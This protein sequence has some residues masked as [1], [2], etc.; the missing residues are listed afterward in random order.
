MNENTKSDIDKAAAEK[1]E[2]LNLTGTKPLPDR[3]KLPKLFAAEDLPMLGLHFGQ[4]W[5]GEKSM[6]EDEAEE[7]TEYLARMSKKRQI[8]NTP[9]V[10]TRGAYTLEE[11]IWD[12]VKCRRLVPA[13]D[14][15]RRKELR[16]KTQ[17]LA[18]KL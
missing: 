16:K 2:N 14:I 15:K 7:L 17:K 11:Y 6:G 10:E 8:I 18:A 3:K 4:E 5:K 12:Q 1:A 13:E 9:G